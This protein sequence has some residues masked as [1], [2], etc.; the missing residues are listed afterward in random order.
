MFQNSQ[1]HPYG[2]RNIDLSLACPP[3]GVGEHLKVTKRSGE[4]EEF[5]RSKTKTAVMRAGA[6]SDEA[7]MIIN[8]LLPGFYDGITTEEI[9]RRVRAMLNARSAA[10]Y[11][12]KKAILAL[13]PDGRN[14]ETLVFRLF[15]AM[16]YDAKVRQL[17]NGR[18][19]TH[20][21][22][23]M[24]EKEG[25][26]FMVECKFHN[27]LSLKCAVQTALYTYGRF[28][29]VD[30]ACDLECPYL[31]TNTR[32]TSEVVKYADCVG[33]R[34]IGWKQPEKGGLEELVERYHLY[35]VTMLDLK[36]SDIRTLLE[37]D[38]VLVVDVLERKD[39]V[40][41]SLG[42]DSALNAFHAAEMLC[43]VGPERKT[44]GIN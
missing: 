5:D 17:V 14:F 28:L 8:K 43:F 42:K 40:V 33:M 26:H 37:K 7:D 11:G 4:I 23:V 13:G 24:M 32:F 44:T 36:K 19:L 2:S 35:P 39:E 22:D 38:M 6:M 31:V 1:I 25:Q 15:Q 34:L 20:E 16:G 29:D 12:L 9:Y 10:R 18:C 30:G 27:S 3:C 21:V 41:R